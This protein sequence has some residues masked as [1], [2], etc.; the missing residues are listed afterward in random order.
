MTST[1]Q[2]VDIHGSLLGSMLPGHHAQAF[3][4]YEIAPFAALVFAMLL[5]VLGLR[6]LPAAYAAWSLIGLLLPLFYPTDMR[7]LYSLHRFVLLLYPL[8]MV[9]A[10]VTRRLG[11][12]RWLLLAACAAGLVFYTFTFAAFGPIG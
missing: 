11:W 6:R 5:I 10:V 4:V 3:V 7:P 1:D 8:F 12:L 9:E 2:V